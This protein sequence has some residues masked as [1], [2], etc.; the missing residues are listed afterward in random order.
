[1]LVV[2]TNRAT[3]FCLTWSLLQ[4][5]WKWDGLWI[6]RLQNGSETAGNGRN[7]ESWRFQKTVLPL[8]VSWKLAGMDLLFPIW[9]CV[10]L[11]CFLWRCQS[12]NSCDDGVRCSVSGM[13]SK[14]VSL[15]Q[16]RGG[17][18]ATTWKSGGVGE[19]IWQTI[20]IFFRKML[21]F[22]CWMY[23]TL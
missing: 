22:C 18:V 7:L 21:L 10:Y 8:L 14:N 12:C 15:V 1:M 11:V 3:F 17:T 5:R 13:D 20:I 23:D 2:D 19:M 16:W 9:R 6:A 4:A